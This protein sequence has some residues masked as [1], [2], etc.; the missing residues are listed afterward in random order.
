MENYTEKTDPREIGEFIARVYRWRAEPITTAFLEA[1]TE[2]NFHA[3]RAELE[4]IIS[5][6]LKG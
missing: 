4:P 3:L 6:H 5:N 2:A 1:L